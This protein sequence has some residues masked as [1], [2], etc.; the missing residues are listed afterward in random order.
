MV[1]NAPRGKLS[2]QYHLFGIKY[3]VEIKEAEFSVEDI[4]EDANLSKS[5]AIEVRKGMKLSEFVEIKN[6]NTFG[7]LQDCYEEKEDLKI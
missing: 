4:I 5:L 6:D 2:V 1:S 7:R 3:N